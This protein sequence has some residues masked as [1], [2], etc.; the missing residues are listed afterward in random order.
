MSQKILVTGATGTVGTSVV[1]KLTALQADFIAATRDPNQAKD[2]L[3]KAVASIRFD[4][5]DP[6]TYDAATKEVD[7]IFLLGPP[8]NFEL[9]NLL[10]PFLD[11]LKTK[12][13]IRVVY[14]SAYGMESLD[15]TSLDFHAK[16]EKRLKNEEFD[17]TIIRPGF[18]A[19]N[20]GNYERE[21]IIERGILFTPAGEGSTPW[22]S[23]RDIGEVI[24]RV[25]VESGH[26]HQTYVLTGKESLSYFDIAQ[27][28]TDILGRPIH[29]TNPDEQTYRQTLLQA[30]IPEFIPDYMYTIYGLI[31]EGV[32]KEPTDIVKQITGHDPISLKAVLQADFT[33]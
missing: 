23:T 9:Y 11:Y 33:S 8:L 26:E 15:N 30:G 19:Q 16:M 31:R 18:F 17:Y 3:G 25:L 5:T 12:D 21:N 4:F 1:E 24:A 22:I 7:K 27:Q 29:Y 14:L 13:I 10:S 32:V 28:L 2:K 20:F 6:S